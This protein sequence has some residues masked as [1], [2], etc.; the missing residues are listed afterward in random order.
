MFCKSLQCLKFP[1]NYSVHPKMLIQISEEFLC[2]MLTI[3]SACMIFRTLNIICGLISVD[4][5]IY[6][7]LCKSDVL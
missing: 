7:H 5:L 3:P 2:C 4:L 1:R 6:T